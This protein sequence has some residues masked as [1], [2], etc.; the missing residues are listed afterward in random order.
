MIMISKVRKPTIAILDD[1]ELSRNLYERWFS[2]LCGK[3]VLFPDPGNLLLAIMK[4]KRYDII[5]IDIN[6]G[7]SQVSGVEVAKVLKQSRPKTVVCL[8]TGAIMQNYTELQYSDIFCLEKSVEERNMVPAILNQW[9]I[10]KA[11]DAK[12]HEIMLK[13]L[14]QLPYEHHIVPTNKRIIDGTAEVT[15]FLLR[16]DGKIALEYARAV[17][18]RH[19]NHPGKFSCGIM[20]MRGCYAGCL[21]CISCDTKC[22]KV[23]VFTAEELIAQI[24]HSL[25]SSQ[26]AFGCLRGDYVVS[27]EATCGGDYIYC[28]KSVNRMIAETYAINLLKMEYVITT[29]GNEKIL[30]KAFPAIVGYPVRIYLSVHSLV[31]EKREWLMPATK[32]QSVEKL[33]EILSD[34]TRKVSVKHPNCAKW[35]LCWMLIKGF[36]D[37]ME[38]VEKIAELF[39]S[40]PDWPVDV[41]V[42][43]ATGEKIAKYFPLILGEEDGRNFVQKLKEKGVDARFAVNIGSKTEG[44]YMSCG[45]TRTIYDN[46]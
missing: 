19:P 7:P 39:R 26:F 45:T 38:D 29:I 46:L 5:L 24:L 3:V 36:N 15:D 2:K 20:V 43:L 11:R 30:Q 37:S 35:T 21:M 28:Y 44:A 22:G 27:V 16:R 10:T 25:F 13:I 9:H 12:S 42:M 18:Y 41:K 6:L 23:T 40:H 34:F 14:Q 17:C 4:G 32:G 8:M 33:G 1:D 31:Q